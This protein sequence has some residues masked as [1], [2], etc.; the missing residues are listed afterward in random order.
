[1]LGKAEQPELMHELRKIMQEQAE[2]QGAGK[3]NKSFNKATKL[4]KESKETS[5]PMKILKGAGKT[6]LGATGAHQVWKYLK[7]IL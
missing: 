6:A 7:S 4:Y 2:Q 3:I 1:M 5:M